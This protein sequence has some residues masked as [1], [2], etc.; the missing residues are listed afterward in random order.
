MRQQLLVALHSFTLQGIDRSFHI[1]GVPQRD[2]CR[3]SAGAIALIFRFTI[4]DFTQ[5]VQEYRA[6][7]RVTGFSFIQSRLDP[8]TK[9][10]IT[11]LQW[12]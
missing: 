1:D 7:Q 10:R 6:R 2:S 5:T 8:P 4:P 9:C 3:Q 12:W 11:L